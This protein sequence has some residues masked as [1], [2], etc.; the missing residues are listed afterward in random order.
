MGDGASRG[1]GV[2]ADG[3]AVG[4]TARGVGGRVDSHTGDGA[5]ERA[6]DGVNGGA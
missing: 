6:G 4:R 1:V 3:I 2:S 5:G